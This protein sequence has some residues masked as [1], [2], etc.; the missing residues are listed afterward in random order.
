M[1]DAL[2]AAESYGTQVLELMAQAKVALVRFHEDVFPGKG[3]PATIKELV[4]VIGADEDPLVSYSHA[5][6]R[7]GAEVALTLA[8]GHGI[9]GDY[10]KAT[11]EF[12]KG[13]DGKLV[14]ITPFRKR[15]RKHAK[16]L[17]VLVAQRAAE[18]EKET[19]E[20]AATEQAEVATESEAA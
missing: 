13:P 2:T 16:R 11:S 3:P 19:T 15:A 7:T 20:E 17:A 1:S 10:Q 5:Q 6:T 14:D 4:E 8:M 9:E 12:P 18:R